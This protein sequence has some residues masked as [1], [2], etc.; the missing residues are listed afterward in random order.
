MYF[1]VKTFVA[2]IAFILVCGTLTAR[3]D[4]GAISPKEGPIKLF[5]GEN[6]DGLYTWLQESKYED[7]KRVFAIEDG[8][9]HVSGDGMGYVCTKNRYRDY[10]L[11]VEYRWGDKTY[12]SRKTMAKSSGIFIHCEDEDGTYQGQFMAAIEAQI[13]EGG[14]GDIELIPGHRRD[15]SRIVLALTSEIQDQLD[16]IGQP[17]WKKGGKR[18]RITDKDAWRISWFGHEPQW[19]NVLGYRGKNDLDSPGKEWTRL[20]L[21]CDGGHVRFLV[22]GVLANEAFDASPRE[23]KIFLQCEEAE[24]FFRRFE[25]LPLK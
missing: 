10:H 24:I 6:L 25:L 17:V 15:G 18:T 21:I 19:K 12:G 5:N 23:G 22:N 3:A 13:I 16:S 8:V 9:L 7:P 20:D 11:V 14:T 4:N 2:G 1:G